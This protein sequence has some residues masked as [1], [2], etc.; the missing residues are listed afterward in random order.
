[1]PLTKHLQLNNAAI[2]I[3]HINEDVMFFL[4]KFQTIPSV[5]QQVNNISNDKKKLEY[6][7]SRYL[8][9]LHGGEDY[10]M[11]LNKQQAGKPYIVNHSHYISISHS[12]KHAAFIESE[13]CCGIDIEAIN[14]RVKKIADRFLNKS[15]FDF[16][17]TNNEIELLTLFWSAKETIYKWYGK[18]GIEFNTQILLQNINHKSD[19]SNGTLNYHFIVNENTLQLEVRF[20]KNDDSFFTYLLHPEIKNQ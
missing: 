1:M 6:L 3:W 13:I 4:S 10:L 12:A 14:L 2:F 15:E 9:L 18:G 17:N 11:N 20:Q 8:L 16:L 19:Y 5:I 7:A